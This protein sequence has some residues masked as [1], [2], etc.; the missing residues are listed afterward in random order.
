[1]PHAEV[2]GQRLYYEE[3]GEGEPLLCVMGLGAD[4]RAWALQQRAWSAEY[5]TV[6]FD[7]RD[8]GRSSYVDG[9]YEVADMSRDALALADELGLDSFHLVG[10]SLG[11]AIAQ[12]MA[13]AAPER[14]RTLTLVVTY[15]GTGGWGPE[16]A[17]LLSAA[18]TRMSREEQV[19]FMMMLCFSESF[20]EDERRFAGLRQ[21]LLANPE[22]QS[23]EAFARQ[24]EAG[25]RHDTRGRIG[26]LAMPVQV[27]GAERDMLVP[28]WK[29]KELAE[30]IPGSRLTILEGSGHAVNLEAADELNRLVLEFLAEQRA[31]AAAE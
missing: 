14:V 31:G 11:G 12:E 8:V 27:I 29:S 30:L 13:L 3:Q 9:P 21:I 15:A 7:N 2:N 24:A 28:V 16:R 22:P 23:P 25:G 5:R 17:R 19:D 26:R 4:A 20:Y 1:V 10:M 6:V 18:M